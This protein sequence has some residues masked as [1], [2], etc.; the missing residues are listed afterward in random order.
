MIGD[1]G[2]F[3]VVGT[4]RLLDVFWSCSVCVGSWGGVG[5][6]LSCSADL[7]E[8]EEECLESLVLEFVRLFFVRLLCRFFLG[9]VVMYGFQISANVAQ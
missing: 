2:C 1:M 5:V 7:M 3:F 8:E 4:V 6:L 9:E